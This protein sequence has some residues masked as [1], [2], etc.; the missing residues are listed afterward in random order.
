MRGK[1]RVNLLGNL[2]ADPDIRHTH[3]GTMVA[4]L[5]IATNFSRTNRDTG[6][7]TEHAE[8]H[9]V[10]AFGPLA[11]IA[12]NYLNKGSGVDVEGRLR[13]RKWQAQDGHDRY[14][15]EIVIN[16][17]IMLPNGNRNGNANDASQA[18]TDESSA[19]PDLDDDIP[20]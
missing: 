18:P 9:R 17:L 12:N 20:F 1:N 14:S 6:E 10:V 19:A 11:E 13:T 7:K 16:E 3:D 5:R 4:N 8:W 2:G 15:T